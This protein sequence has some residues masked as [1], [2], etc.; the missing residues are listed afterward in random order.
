MTHQISFTDKN[1]ANE[2]HSFSLCQDRHSDSNRTSELCELC[3]QDRTTSEVLHD[4]SD[5]SRSSTYCTWVRYDWI[6][7]LRCWG[8]W[9]TRR[10]SRLLPCKKRQSFQVVYAFS[11]EF[12]LQFSYRGLMIAKWYGPSPRI[13]GWSYRPCQK[14]CCIGVKSGPHWREDSG[15][16][17]FVDW[18]S[19]CVLSFMILTVQ[20]P[21][22]MVLPQM[23][24][25]L[26][27]LHVGNGKRRYRKELSRGW[28]TF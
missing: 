16:L 10:R 11:Y 12:S 26:L 17:E 5:V 25:V 2:I 20:R 28:Y 13:V 23:M 18:L 24:A 14:V 4:Y 7:S 21:E 6:C 27:W 1:L 9:S 15:Q 22:R 8:P 19:L 3:L